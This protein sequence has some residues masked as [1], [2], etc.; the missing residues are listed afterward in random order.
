MADGDGASWSVALEPYDVVGIRLSMPGVKLSQPQVTWPA[1]VRQALEA[2][3]AELGNR[4]AALRNPPVLQ[5]LNNPGFERP[6]TADGQIPGWVATSQPEVSIDLDAD[7]RHSGAQALR[8]TSRGPTASLISQPFEVPATGRLTMSVWLRVADP[9]RQ[10]I[11]QLAL[12]GKLNG[13]NFRRVAHV[14]QSPDGQTLVKPL[15]SA[16]APIVVRVDDLPLEGL[17][18]LQLGFELVGPGEVWIDDIQL[19]S[20]DFGDELVELFKLLWP[21]EGYLQNGRV[22]DCMNLLEGYWPRFLA[23]Y[24]P[25]VP[26]QA[27]ARSAAAAP[28]PRGPAVQTEQSVGFFSRMKRLLPERW[29][30]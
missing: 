15:T 1:G 2:R 11:L 10:P 28:A 29:R 5:V 23:A 24:V 12:Q 26:P 14:G 9:L 8:V 19:C 3:V 22:S 7:Q 20:L 4:A 16:W 30:Y 25:A 27:S 18:Q 21:A 17:S 13:H 6:K